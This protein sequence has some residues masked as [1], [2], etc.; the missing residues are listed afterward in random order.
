MK[1]VLLS[2]FVLGVFVLYSIHLKLDQENVPVVAIRTLAPTPSS[3]QTTSQGGGEPPTAALAPPTA[4]PQGKYKDGT[5]VG[6]AADAFY[7]NIQVQVTI[8][9]GKITDVAFL[10]YPNDR[11]T[12][13]FINSQA[14]PL[15]K[16]EA[17]QAQSA[18]VDGVSGATA[19][20]GAFIQSLQSALQKA[21]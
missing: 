3:Q 10:Q 12:S 13:V 4:T 17:I 19:S 16:Q 1:K 21:V 18:Q 7:G 6:D 14:M 11:S 2:A 8:T 15:L 20:S 9:G 5:Y